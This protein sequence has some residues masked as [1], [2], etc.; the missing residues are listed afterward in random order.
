MVAMPCTSL[1]IIALI[2]TVFL[3]IILAGIREVLIGFRH[4]LLF[5]F[6]L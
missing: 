1:V 6:S 3:A 2:A 4:F 5:L